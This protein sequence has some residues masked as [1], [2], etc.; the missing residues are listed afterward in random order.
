MNIDEKKE[1]AANLKLSGQANCSQAVLLALQDETG[2]DETTSK[3][4][5][6]GFCAGMGN[7]NGTCGALIG[8]I[9]AA[10]L[11]TKGVA[12]LKSARLMNEEFARL[13]GALKCR[14]LKSLTDG[15]PLCPCDDCVR[16]AIIVYGKY[17]GE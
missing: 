13:S 9:M 8:A 3:A 17:M 6:A 10:G 5:G 2:L 15:K 14:D 12:T 1:Y 7:M 4:L 11:K 16:N